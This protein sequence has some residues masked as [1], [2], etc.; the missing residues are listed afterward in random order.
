MILNLTTKLAEAQKQLRDTQHLREQFRSHQ[1]QNKRQEGRW[2]VERFINNVLLPKV[3]ESVQMKMSDRGVFHR[4]SSSLRADQ[5][6]PMYNSRPAWVPDHWAK[7][8]TLCE[9]EFSRTKRKHHCRFCGNVFCAACSKKRIAIPSIGYNKPVRVCDACLPKASQ[10]QPHHP[11][12]FKKTIRK[13]SHS[14][15]DSLRQIR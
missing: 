8:C 9:R 4:S 5:S 14:L 10:Q 1:A 11:P 12:G 7:V 13:R 3:F 2:E 6:F 15:D